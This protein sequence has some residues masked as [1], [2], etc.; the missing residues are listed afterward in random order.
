MYLFIALLAMQVIPVDHSNPSADP[1]NDFVSFENVPQEEGILIKGACYDCHSNHT[2]YPWYSKV[3]PVSFWLQSH[4]DHG[5]D[6][7]NFSLWNSYSEKRKAHKIEECIE[8]V[9]EKSMPLKSY[10]WTHPSARLSDDERQ[11]LLTLFKS[12][13]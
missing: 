6:E 13:L 2:R 4:V 7:L 8:K 9:E 11:M 12:K 1:K 10:T 3:A 5:R